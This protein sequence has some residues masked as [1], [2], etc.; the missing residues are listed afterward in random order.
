LTV[1]PDLKKSGIQ[2]IFTLLVSHTFS[3]DKVEILTELEEEV[4]ILSEILTS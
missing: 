2:S 3:L 4:E 1:Q